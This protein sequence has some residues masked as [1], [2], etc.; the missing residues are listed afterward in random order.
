M[1]ASRA[2]KKTSGFWAVPRTTGASGRQAAGPEREDVVVADQR[3]DVVLVEDGDLVDLVRRPEAIEEVQERDP[4]PQRGGVRDEREVVRLL[5]R[6]GGEHRPARRPRVHH[7]AVVAEDRE[8]VG[9]DRPGRDMD[10]G[11]RQLAARS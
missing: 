5:D 7:V 3:P 8:R 1:D 9:R 11:G 10:D 4:R 2:W 6:A